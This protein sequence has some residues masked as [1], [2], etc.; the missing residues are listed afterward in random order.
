MA[1]FLWLGIR[2]R[3]EIDIERF[4]LKALRGDFGAVGVASN[5]TERVNAAL[6]GVLR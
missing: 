1:V 6:Q 2:T 5:T 3:R 4:A